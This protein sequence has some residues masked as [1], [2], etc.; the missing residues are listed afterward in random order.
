[1]YL[2]RFILLFILISVV[3]RLIGR[4]LFSVSRGQQN[5]QRTDFF[6]KGKKKEGRVTVMMDP[7]NK[8]RKKIVPKTDGE[9]I[10]YEEVDK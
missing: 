4:I 5:D 9:Y 7:E 2:I 1:M 3:L 6:E 8:G 10:K